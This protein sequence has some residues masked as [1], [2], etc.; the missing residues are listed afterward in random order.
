[1]LKLDLTNQVY[2]RLTVIS[3]DLTK[4]KRNKRYWICKCQCG[5]IKSIPQESLRSSRA[6]SCGCIKKENIKNST[7]RKKLCDRKIWRKRPPRNSTAYHVWSDRYKDGLSF[8]EF[9]ILSQQNC[10]YC[11]QEPSNMS[12][13]YKLCKR[14]SSFAKDS[15]YFCYNGLDR[16]DNSKDH[17]TTNVVP[18]CKWCNYSKR[19]M[20]QTEFILYIKRFHNYQITI[21][22]NENEI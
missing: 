22:K 6:K 8:D 11:N 13:I 9:L 10:F 4:N 7:T 21:S 2:N 5:N 12:N 16:I 1:M 15:G 20:S 3:L 19:D 17:S 14:S 18:C